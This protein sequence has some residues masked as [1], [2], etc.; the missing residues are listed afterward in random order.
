[1]HCPKFVVTVSGAW[2][3]AVHRVGSFGCWLSH[4]VQ[5]PQFVSPEHAM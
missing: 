2:H 3:I 1:M 4:V 5:Q